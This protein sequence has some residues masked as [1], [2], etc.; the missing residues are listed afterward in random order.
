MMKIQ[1]IWRA[2]HAAM[3]WL[4]SVVTLLA[5]IVAS[6]QPARAQDTIIDCDRV[7]GVTPW[8]RQV[9]AVNTADV[10]C[11]QYSGAA[12]A[13][14]MQRLNG[15]A[16]IELQVTRGAFDV[17]VFAAPVTS[18]NVAQQLND[19][20]L[21]ATGSKW[22]SFVFNNVSAAVNYVIAIAP[23]T[24]ARGNHRLRMRVA[25]GAVP[26]ATAIPIPPVTTFPTTSDAPCSRFALSLSGLCI[27]PFPVAFNGTLSVLWRIPD[28]RYGELDKGD[29]RGFV[30]PIAWQQKVD[31]PNI[32]APRVIRLRWIDTAGRQF[33]DSIL[34][35]V[36]PPAV[37]PTPKVDLFPCSRAGMG[38]SNLCIEP[39][40]P[41]RRG[42]SAFVVWRIVDFRYGE[43]DSGDGRG[44]VGPIGRE[45]RVEVP[46]MHAPRHIRLRWVDSSNQWREDSFVIQVTDVTTPIP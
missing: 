12:I 44:F 39:P 7:V 19:A 18:A 38:V 41:V 25:P 20:P 6:P 11:Y 37:T 13:A 10:L 40:Y 34:T 16:L 32:V 24:E 33:V 9:S 2:R 27:D 36:Q 1:Q 17:F 22:H 5:G 14:E 4:M 15:A 35:Q 45:Q 21:A 29:G 23:A 28:F 30:G 3:A 31:V 26:P 46:G 43:F 42:T 8:N